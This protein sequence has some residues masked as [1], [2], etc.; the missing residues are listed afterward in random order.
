MLAVSLACGALVVWRLT[1]ADTCMALAIPVA[2]IGMI[3]VPTARFSI[4]RRRSFA[5]SFFQPDTFLRRWFSGRT[6][7][8]G[9][10][11]IASLV[12]GSSLML[13]IVGWSWEFLGVLGIDAIVVA[14]VAPYLLNLGCSQLKPVVA[15][16]AAHSLLSNVNAV[17]LL[18]PL[19]LVQ[20]HADYPDFV[21]RN[22][23]LV[24]TIEAARATVSSVCPLVDVLVD[25]NAAK[26]AFA[27]WLVIMAS[28]QA[29]DTSLRLAVWV[30]FLMFGS[31]NA[32]A[33]SKLVVRAAELGMD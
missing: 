30:A 6:I 3:A 13:S 21:D 8:I 22:G 12:A 20:F 4:L 7:A 18:V 16:L 5:D 27:W 14:L 24:R 19:V 31:L 25:F 15:R 17:L 26:D 1:Y 29:Q 33:F 28:Q 32:W 11:M 9:S 23:S 10:A 2:C